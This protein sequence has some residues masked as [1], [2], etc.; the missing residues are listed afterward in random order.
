M[1]IDYDPAAWLRCPVTG[2]DRTQW[3]DRALAALTKD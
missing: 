2:D 3:H 1:I